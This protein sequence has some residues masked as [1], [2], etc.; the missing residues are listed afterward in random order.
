MLLEDPLLAAPQPTA[1]LYRYMPVSRF[2]Q[3]IHEQALW[4]SRADRLGDALEGSFT[5][6]DREL[7]AV[8]F[9]D[10]PVGQKLI[11]HDRT[12]VLP[13]LTRLMFINCWH[14]QD[15]ESAHMWSGYSDDG[16][17]IRTTGAR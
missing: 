15:H 9:A 14:E 1:W 2:R 12:V 13:A 6:R 3:L 5:D 8:A 17:A 10:W 16:V 4:F 11:D 7:R